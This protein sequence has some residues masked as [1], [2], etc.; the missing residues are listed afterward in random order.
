MEI[1][2]LHLLK[3]KQVKGDG[4]RRV[5]EQGL[6]ATSELRSLPLLRGNKRLL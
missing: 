2:G 6:S 5:G 4:V 1:D 3:M